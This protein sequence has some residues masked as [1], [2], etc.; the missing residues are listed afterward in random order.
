MSA[1]DKTRFNLMTVLNGD[2]FD[3]GKVFVNSLYDNIDRSRVN[4]LYVYDTGLDDAAR[5]FLSA[6]PDLE[7]V[8]THLNTRHLMLHDEDWRRNVYSKTAFLQQVVDR[9]RL[10][11]IMVDSDCLFLRDFFDLIPTDRD[12]VACRRRDVDAFSEY[13][14]SF[15]VINAV[16]RA[17]AMIQEWRD[18]MLYGTENH[19]ESPALT[20][21]IARGAHDF[22]DM[23]EDVISYT[24]TQI[25]DSVKI[26]HMK[27][28][29]TLRTVAQRIHQPCLAAYNARYFSDVPIVVRGTEREAAFIDAGLALPHAAAQAPVL[30]AA[31]RLAEQLSKVTPQQRA[32]LLKRLGRSTD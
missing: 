13:I 12:F 32:L 1:H 4:K 15:F 6:F 26:V 29:A 23:D 18:E 30:S 25:D 19:K 24:G 22:A 5:H 11:T 27:S 10:P 9:D 8:S 17:A 31:E 21:V 20:R 14:A 2:Y 28:S 16:D 3:F 7:V